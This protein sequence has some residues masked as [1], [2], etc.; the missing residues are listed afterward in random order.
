MP[1]TPSSPRLQQVRQQ[2]DDLDALLERMLALPLDAPPPSGPK[3]HQPADPLTQSLDQASQVSLPSVVF[4]PHSQPKERP[5]GKQ[6]SE[7]AEIITFQPLV[8]ESNQE[9]IPPAVSPVPIPA[10]DL[11]PAVDA[12]PQTRAEDLLIPAPVFRE[13]VPTQDQSAPVAQEQ[14]AAWVAPLKPSKDEDGSSNQPSLSLPFPDIQP[15]AEPVREA[16]VARQ[17]AYPSPAP[18][19]SIEETPGVVAVRS[20]WWLAVLLAINGLYDGLAA[21]LGFLGRWTQRTWG[22]HLLGGTGLVLLVAAAALALGRWL[23]MTWR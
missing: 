16:T 15:Q 1:T 11:S 12:A 19:A 17:V 8:P 14:P 21:R 4:V 18:F 5:A 23:G 7:P 22:R 10:A 6:E 9:E 13:E 3:L 2:L 20:P